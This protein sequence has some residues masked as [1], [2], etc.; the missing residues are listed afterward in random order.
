[1]ANHSADKSDELGDKCRITRPGFRDYGGYRAFEGRVSTV[2]CFEDN[3]L[4][5]EATRQ[6]GEGRVLVVDGG[7]SMNCALLGD[8]LARLACENDWAGIVIN[9][10]IRDSAT[11]ADMPIGVKALETHPKKSEKRGSGERDVAVHFAGVTIKPGDYIYCDS[12]GILV[13]DAH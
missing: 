9:G 12:D 2:R 4:V 7:A 8:R 10:C 13:A 11:I 3:S 1:M 6:P 5:R